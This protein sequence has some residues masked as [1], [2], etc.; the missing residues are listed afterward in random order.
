M[1]RIVRKTKSLLAFLRHATGQEE[2]YAMLRAQH[3]SLRF[4]EGFSLR[5]PE[6]FSPGPDNYFE[7]NVYVN[8]GEEWA[9]GRGYFRSGKRCFVGASTVIYAAGGVELGD[10]VGIGVHCIIVSHQQD[11]ARDKPS[12]MAQESIYSPVKI[13]NNVIINVGAVVLQG[14]TIGD[15]AII[16]ASAVVTR[17]VPANSV[18]MGVPARVV[19]TC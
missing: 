2:F 17:D 9:G 1:L 14:V 13:G 18:V 16:G 6:R 12:Y 4:R 11:F 15:N 19:R 7:Q 3:P 10:D 8:C 5:G